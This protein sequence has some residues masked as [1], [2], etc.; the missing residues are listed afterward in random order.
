M[1]TLAR[2]LIGISLLVFV[3]AFFFA[4]GMVVQ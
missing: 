2:I 3:F 1:G 4:L